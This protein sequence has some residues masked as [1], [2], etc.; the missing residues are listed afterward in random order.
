MKKRVFSL[1]L[2]LC[3]IL[4][5]VPALTPEVRAAET[6]KV[7]TMAD[8]KAALE[9]NGD[10]EITVTKEIVQT[11]TVG[12][13]KQYAAGS[14]YITLGSGQKTLD[15]A[16]YKVEL[17]GEGGGLLTFLRV[18]EGAELTIRDS[19][20]KQTG[21]LWCDGDMDFWDGSIFLSYFYTDLRC[22]HVIA[23][24]GGKLTVKSGSIESG[25]TKNVYVY[26]GVTVSEYGYETMVGYEI[27][28]TIVVHALRRY[29]ANAYEIVGGDAILLNGGEVTIDGGNIYGRG[30]TNM[31]AKFT[32]ERM[33]GSATRA[34]AI[35]A[36]SGKLTI[37]AGKLYGKGNAD[38]LNLSKNVDFTLKSGYFET[39]LLRNFVFENPSSS[40]MPWDHQL[41]C[42]AEDSPYVSRT[43]P[44]RG[45]G[46]FGIPVDALDEKNHTLKY[47]GNPY[48]SEDWGAARITNNPD[49]KS[50]SLSAT[51]HASNAVYTYTAA[52]LAAAVNIASVDLKGTMAM[53]MSLTQDTVKSSNPNVSVNTTW[54]RDSQ[55]ITGTHE[56]GFGGYLARVEVRANKGYKL[57]TATKYTIL[58]DEPTLVQHTSDGSCAIV[59]SQ[60]YVFKCDHSYNEDW[61]WHYDE[62]KHYQQCTV[63]GEKIAEEAHTHTGSDFGNITTY[64][65]ACGH[66]YDVENGKTK[67]NGLVVDIPVAIV[68][69]PIPQPKL[70]SEFDGMAKVMSWSIASAT[71]GY[72][73]NAGS[74]YEAGQT[75]EITVRAK[76]NDGYYFSPDAKVNCAAT[77]LKTQDGDDGV[78]ITTFTI[79]PVA[80]SVAYVT[81][82]SM[83]GT[84]GDFIREIQATVNG[85]DTNNMQITIK[86]HGK[87][88]EVYVRKTLSG[89][90]QLVR[91]AASLDAFWKTAIVPDTAYDFSFDF[92]TNSTYVS[93]ESINYY[94]PASYEGLTLE[95]GSVWFTVSGVV[96]ADSNKVNDVS[97]VS[98][99]PPFAG[100]TPEAD[101]DVLNA[102]ALDPGTGSWDATGTFDYNTEYTFTA[103]AK[104]KPGYQFADTVTA[105]MN[106]AAA[107][108]SVSGSTATVKYTFPATEQAV[109]VTEAPAHPQQQGKALDSIAITTKPNRISFTAGETF[110]T[111]G[112]V[113]TATYT[114][115]TSAAV[116]GYTVTPSGKLTVNDKA[117]TVSYTE[118]SVTKTATLNIVVEAAKEQPKANP[119]T[120]VPSN[121]TYYYYD[122]ILWAYYHQPQITTGTSAT[123]FDLWMTCDRGQ[124][125]TFLWRAYGCPTPKSA[126]N[127]FTDLTQ[128]WYKTAVQWAVEQ[129]ITNGTGANTFS[130]TK[131]CSVAE[132][133]TFL[134]RAAG[135]P[136][137]TAAPAAWY[138]DAMNWATASGLIQG[139]STA[140][141]AANCPRA[142]IVT[143]LY[144]QFGK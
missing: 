26:N 103:T 33:E 88:D 24:D 136:G 56:V 87:D 65:C 142:D 137:E 74:P 83:T 95:G 129:G 127:S 110:D 128:D 61:S 139:T 141:P 44:G 113:V 39:Q 86:T 98:V 117:V 25:R 67:I 134:W 131:T 66:S 116:T 112:M 69:D 4:C 101:Y 102:A 81:L 10:A 2:S 138:T 19:S 7:G 30:Y 91:G 28:S 22:R 126:A 9:K 97:I 13:Y 115:G 29:D 118:G 58:G 72:M 144:R 79:V 70:L 84:M 135:K 106:G 18:P 125:V 140:D 15:L 6:V 47:D 92:S 20:T 114:D 123:T 71:T 55:P 16:G 53:G 35:V 75:Y 121:N 90:W 94:S 111:T 41:V 82:P 37:N 38:V 57:T 122:P 11:V 32:G 89:G 132:V 78:I 34:A 124:V 31:E 120:D 96:V 17:N 77:T 143:Y 48:Y 50:H 109:E 63:C 85:K 23:V 104:L 64:S 36:N 46:R 1:I 21:L 99:M 54:Y 43:D 52:D 119:F 73:V 107:Q 80:R 8:L 133:I 5:L 49:E 130:P 3:M 105:S 42:E 93:D 108:V 40:T 59:W 76:A 45:A 62:A 60:P 100:N 12:Y 51:H 14:T 68:G 27:N